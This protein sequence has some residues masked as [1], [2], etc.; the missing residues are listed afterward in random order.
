MRDRVGHQVA[1]RLRQPVGVGDQRPRRHRPQFEAA[2][3]KQADPVPQVPHEP[4]QVDRREPQELRLLGLR[5]QQQ[6][7]DQPR[8]ARDLGLHETLHPAH[9]RRGRLGL[10]RQHLQL[11]ADHRQRRAQLVRRVR[12]ERPLARERLRQAVEH[13]V[14]RV[15][16][17]PHLLALAAHIVDAGMQVAGVH[18]CRHR[19]HPPQRPREARPDQQ[20]RR[21][22]PDERQ[23]PRQDERPRHAPL[24]VRDARQR[25]PHPNRH[26]GSAGDPHRPLE[27]TQVADVGQVQRAV[28]G[29]R[30]QQ[31]PRQAVLLALLGERLAVV[32]RRVAEQLRPVGRNPDPGH[33]REQQRRARAERLAAHVA[34]RGPRN[35]AGRAGAGGREGVRQL[36]GIAFDLLVDLAMQLGPGAAVDRHERDPRGDHHHQRHPRR[37]TP[38]QPAQR[39]HARPARRSPPHRARAG[40]RGVHS[41]ARV[42]GAGGPNVSAHGRGGSR[43][44]APCRSGPGIGPRPPRAAC[45]A[46]TRRRR[47]RCWSPGRAGSPTPR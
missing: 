14:E 24:G 7:V 17:H 47:P 29:A 20:R 4:P 42:R 37:Q 36:V 3:G 38:A 35:L 33:Q 31:P 1:Q 44:P 9:L 43:P 27:Q 25:L 28:S 23:Q 34:R 11:A 10:G 6:I 41:P 21:Q 18:L 13:V 46:D 19:R 16:Q 39:R 32:G 22:R 12:H 8:H 15:R 40:G 30:R 45:G 26:G 2:I 5:Q